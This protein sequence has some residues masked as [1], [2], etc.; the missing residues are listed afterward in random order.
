MIAEFHN[1]H[2]EPQAP[3]LFPIKKCLRIWGHFTTEQIYLIAKILSW[4]MQMPIIPQDLQSVVVQ[5]QFYR[6]Y[7]KNQGCIPIHAESFQTIKD[8]ILAEAKLNARE[9]ELQEA[10]EK[11]SPSAEKLNSSVYT[12]PINK[13]LWYQYKYDSPFN[14]QRIALER[15]AV[16][17]A[18]AHELIVDMCKQNNWSV[19]CDEL[20]WTVEG[21]AVSTWFPRL[22]EYIRQRLENKKE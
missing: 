12:L 11:I 4:D 3:Q 18:I 5:D 13:T 20:G 9:I 17:N 19:T 2:Q 10:K 8:Q 14:H 16:C 22:C 6:F 15:L 7:L 1:N 21:I